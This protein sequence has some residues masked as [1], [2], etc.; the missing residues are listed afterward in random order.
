MKAFDF[1]RRS[2][3]FI[4]LRSYGR[5]SLSTKQRITTY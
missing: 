1:V 3:E 2:H 5:I 4:I